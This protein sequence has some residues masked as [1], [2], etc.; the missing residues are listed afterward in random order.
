[1]YTPNFLQTRHTKKLCTGIPRIYKHIYPYRRKE[2]PNILEHKLCNCFGQ[3][4]LLKNFE[5]G[6]GHDID[7][8]YEVC[9]HYR[10]S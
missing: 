3:L 5:H 6:I 8:A 10:H 2:F 7:S 1:M 4:L 9:I